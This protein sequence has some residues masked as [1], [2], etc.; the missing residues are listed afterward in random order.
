MMLREKLST[1]TRLST[2]AKLA[3]TEDTEDAEAQSTHCAVANRLRV[4][5]VLCGV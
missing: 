3:T 2:T 5:R 1:T 4:L